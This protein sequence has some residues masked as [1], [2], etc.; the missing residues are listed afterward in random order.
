M[1]YSTSADNRH[2]GRRRRRAIGLMAICSYGDLGEAQIIFLARDVL[3]SLHRPIMCA[4][5]ERLVRVNRE[6]MNWGAPL[7]LNFTSRSYLCLGQTVIRFALNNKLS[8]Q[9]KQQ[10]LIPTAHGNTPNCP[11]STHYR[12]TRLGYPR[13]QLASVSIASITKL[14]SLFF[15]ALR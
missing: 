7:P 8:T 13:L 9:K 6:K 11:S 1:L 2:G 14:P 5:W 3:T 4:G 15:F 10:Q 12:Y